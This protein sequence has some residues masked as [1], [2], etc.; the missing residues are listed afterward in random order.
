MGFNSGFKGLIINIVKNHVLQNS[1]GFVSWNTYLCGKYK[2]ILGRGEFGIAGEVDRA[3]GQ[4][5]WIC[6][7]AFR[8]DYVVGK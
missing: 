7:F 5:M 4:Y 6:V 8:D 3:R 1:R 2:G